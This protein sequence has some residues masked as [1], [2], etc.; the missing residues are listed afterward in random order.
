MDGDEF[1]AIQ[2]IAILNTR[3]Y[4]NIDYFYVYKKRFNDQKYFNTLDSCDN[5]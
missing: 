2:I 5:N 3:K 1:L 4:R